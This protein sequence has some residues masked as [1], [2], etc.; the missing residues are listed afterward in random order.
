MELSGTLTWTRETLDVYENIS[1]TQSNYA[2]QINQQTVLGIFGTQNLLVGVSAGISNAGTQNTFIGANAGT[3]NTSGSHN[4]F[5]G[6]EAGYFKTTGNGNAFTGYRAGYRNYSGSQNA[7]FGDEA[8]HYNDGNNNAFFGNAAGF[9]FFVSSAQPPSNDTFIGEEAGRNTL[10][11]NNT[12]VGYQSGY[13]NIL[14]YSNIYIGNVGGNESGMI[15]IGDV[16]TDTYIAGIYNSAA[17]TGPFQSVCVGTN[18]KLWG[19]SALAS[20]I[21]SSRRFKENILDMGGST[22]KL[23]QLRPVTFFYKPQYDE[24]S[25]ELQYG[26]IAEEVAKVYPEMVVYDKD[27]QPYTVKYQMLAPMLLNEVQ[28]QHAVVAAQ[29][30]ELQTQ[31]QQI[32]AQR[33]EIDGLKLQLQQQNAS[34]QERLT[35]LESY[36]ATQ[37]KTASDNPP[38]TTP[39][40]SGGLQ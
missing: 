34:L 1:L 14:G 38:R 31:V 23:L 17:G 30:D 5:V 4:T 29:Q 19:V 3:G 28:K 36:V 27:G 2:Y 7:F 26:L 10:G 33:Q 32:K 13:N 18:G 25:H 39:G 11:S 22:S 20:C 16:Q 15:R 6:E 40:A 37:M 8:G 35:K 24:G 12:F 9:G 21:T